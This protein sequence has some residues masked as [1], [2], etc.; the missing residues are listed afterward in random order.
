MST[1]PTGNDVWHCSFEGKIVMKYCGGNY[2]IEKSEFSNEQQ[3][4]SWGDRGEC[5]LF[6]ITAHLT[7]RISSQISG[8]TGIIPVRAESATKSHI[9]LKFLCSVF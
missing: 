3:V 4:Y 8:E 7:R 2:Q 6:L 1:L 9:N 5:L